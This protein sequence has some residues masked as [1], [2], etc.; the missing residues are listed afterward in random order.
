MAARISRTTYPFWQT[1][2]KI[3]LMTI[4]RLL[5]RG[6]RFPPLILLDPALAC[7]G[8]T[9]APARRCGAEPGLI[10]TRGNGSRLSH[11]ALRAALRPGHDAYPTLNAQFALPNSMGN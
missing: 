5:C 1:A 6:T 8:R 2:P 9:A 10:S 11:A 3:R 4:S 7:P